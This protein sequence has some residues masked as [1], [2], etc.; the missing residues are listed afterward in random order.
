MLIRL[1]VH[2]DGPL[3]AGTGRAEKKIELPFVPAV[4]TLI[5][6]FAF[7]QSRLVKSVSISTE[8][9]SLVNVYL[10]NEKTESPSHYEQTASGYRERGW[11]V[12]EGGD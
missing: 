10:G 4:G 9:R 6:D 7:S 12:F 1:T 11:S 8:E 2:I 3:G 5:E